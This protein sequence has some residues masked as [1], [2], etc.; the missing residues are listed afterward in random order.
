MREMRLTATAMRFRWG[1]ESES[2]WSAMAMLARV[3]CED[4]GNRRSG[5]EGKY[6][7]YGRLY[8]RPSLVV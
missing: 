7:G 1:V 6:R 8:R 2:S 3:S 4:N 5:G